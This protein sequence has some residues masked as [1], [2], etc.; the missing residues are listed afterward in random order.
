MV[1]GYTVKHQD[2]SA[3]RE[4]T[5]LRTQQCFIKLVA[6]SQQDSLHTARLDGVI[7]L[8]VHENLFLLTG[9]IL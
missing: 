7:N 5:I 9:E 8:K 2:H 1:N 4:H 6:P 3:V